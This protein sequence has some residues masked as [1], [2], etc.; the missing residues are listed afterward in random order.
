MAPAAWKTDRLLTAL[1]VA[2]AFIIFLAH[3]YHNRPDVY[4][5][6]FDEHLVY[7]EYIKV[8]KAVPEPFFCRECG[9]PPPYYAMGVGAFLL[10]EALGLDPIRAIQWMSALFYGVYLVFAIRR[11][12]PFFCH[13]NFLFIFI[14]APLFAL[15]SI[16]FLIRINLPIYEKFL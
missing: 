15:A 5:H 13:Q 2:V 12:Y 10:G 3:F 7:M 4:S 6:D 11:R 1:M 14:V 16:L 9:H 8:Y